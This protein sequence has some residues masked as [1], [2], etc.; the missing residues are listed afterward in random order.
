MGGVAHADSITILPVS[1]CHCAATGSEV[2][3]ASVEIEGKAE[4]KCGD[5]D[6]GSTS[7]KVT[8]Y[9]VGNGLSFSHCTMGAPDCDDVEHPEGITFTSGS[10]SVTCRGGSVECRKNVASM[11]SSSWGYIGMPCVSRQP[12]AT[13][14]DC[15]FCAGVPTPASGCTLIHGADLHGGSEADCQNLAAGNDVDC[16]KFGS[17]ADECNAAKNACAKNNCNTYSIFFHPSCHTDSL[18]RDPAYNFCNFYQCSSKS[19]AASNLDGHCEEKSGCTGTFA[20]YTT[21][22]AEDVA[23]V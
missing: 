2:S 21:L 8:M 11:A 18:G 4:V 5:V 23:M 19:Q 14:V 10:D 20:T 16:S 9:W 12:P 6:R 1:S 22:V 15:Q 13:P 17:H 3:C 7:G